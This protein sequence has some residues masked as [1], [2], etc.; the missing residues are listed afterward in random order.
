MGPSPATSALASVLSVDE[1]S[2][3]DRFERV[4]LED[5]VSVC[6]RAP[7][8][9]AAGRELF[10]ASRQTRTRTTVGDTCMDQKNV[11]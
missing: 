10:A 9:S 11:I 4:Q 2:A 5:I 6:V 3:L 1:V 8:L 7:S